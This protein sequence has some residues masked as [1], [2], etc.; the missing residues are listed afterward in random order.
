MQKKIETVKTLLDALPFIQEFRDEIV[1][2]KYGGS[3]QESPQ[4]K[5]RFAR[6]ILL[7]YLVGIKPVIVHGGGRQ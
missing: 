2:I 5:E 3:A 4:L 7:M 6:D 1:V